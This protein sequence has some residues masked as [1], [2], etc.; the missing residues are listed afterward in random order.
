MPGPN[1]PGA[2]RSA[3]VQPT[4]PVTGFSAHSL[5]F[6]LQSIAASTRD[7]GSSSLTRFHHLTTCWR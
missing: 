2:R 3:C 5:R 7:D 1:A 6:T 4:T